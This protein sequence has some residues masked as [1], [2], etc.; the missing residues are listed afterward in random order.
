[1]Q[2]LSLMVN[3]MVEFFENQETITYVTLSESQWQQLNAHCAA[4]LQD[5][6]TF[7]S[8]DAASIIKRLGLMLYRIAMLL[9]ALRKYE[10]GEV[11]DRAACSDLDFQTALQL[12]QIYR[13]HSI[14]MFHNL[15]KQT[16]ATKFEKGDYKRK[17]YHA[18]PEVFRRA[19]AVLLG[20]HYSVGERTVD[21]LLR[22]AVPSLLTQVKP[23]HYRKL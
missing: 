9:T 1:F 12:A 22:S 13:S 20:K 4:W 8:E 17:F 18:L 10:D 16:N 5:I 3:N 15:P 11:G 14:L 19:D 6:M 23:G 21:E 2:S 7:T